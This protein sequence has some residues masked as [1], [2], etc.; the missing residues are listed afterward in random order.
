M[1][2]TR[3]KDT[4]RLPILPVCASHT[5]AGPRFRSSDP[6]ER[7]DYQEN[8]KS[9][10]VSLSE[11]CFLENALGVQVAVPPRPRQNEGRDIFKMIILCKVR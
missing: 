7:G 2:V 1:P 6:P 3:P 8:C 4:A 9:G 5:R 11:N 10:I